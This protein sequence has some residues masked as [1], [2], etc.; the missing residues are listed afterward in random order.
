MPFPSRPVERAATAQSLG[1]DQGPCR[2]VSL[3]G[4]VEA[5]RPRLMEGDWS[6]LV[7]FVAYA[8]KHGSTRVMVRG[9]IELPAFSF[10]AWRSGHAAWY[11]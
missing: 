10:S 4:S 5:A 8:T 6:C 3:P 11:H 1:G 2:A 7:S 9:R